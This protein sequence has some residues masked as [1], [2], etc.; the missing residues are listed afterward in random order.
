MTGGRASEP[1]PWGLG[2]PQGPGPG[3]QAASD[4]QRLPVTVRSLVHGGAAGPSG[5]LGQVESDLSAP[6]PGPPRGLP[7]LLTLG[8]TRVSHPQLFLLDA[9]SQ[10]D[11]T[12][13]P[14][15]EPEGL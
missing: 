3:A 14:A 1:A 15:C 7:P 13:G 5:D 12:E 2:T 10:A 9:M 8:N 4:A 11:R 6:P